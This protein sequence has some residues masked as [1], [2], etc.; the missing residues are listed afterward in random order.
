MEEFLDFTSSLPEKIEFEDSWITPPGWRCEGPGNHEA[1]PHGADGI[2][3]IYLSCE[4]AL[5]V[6]RAIPHAL[7]VHEEHPRFRGGQ[8]KAYVFRRHFYAEKAPVLGVICCS[9]CLELRRAQ[10]RIETA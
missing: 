10:D 3:V 5:Q 2:A 6:A 8:A 7:V 1:C 4:E 9:Q